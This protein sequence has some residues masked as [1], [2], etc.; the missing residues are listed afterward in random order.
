MNFTRNEPNVRW[1]K[2][3]MKSKTSKIEVKGV[4]KNNVTVK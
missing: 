3:K 2:V 4:L 1:V